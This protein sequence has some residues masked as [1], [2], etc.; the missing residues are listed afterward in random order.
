[1]PKKIRI[2]KQLTAGRPASPI[3]KAAMPEKSTYGSLPKKIVGSHMGYMQTG[4]SETPPVA[5]GPAIARPPKGPPRGK[6]APSF[7]V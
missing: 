6:V 2:N 4:G 5:K 1:M 3:N 7:K